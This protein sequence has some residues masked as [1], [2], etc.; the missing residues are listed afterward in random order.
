MTLTEL[1]YIV[2]V[3]AEGQGEGPRLRGST[4]VRD[5]QRPPVLVEVKGAIA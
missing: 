4:P 2:A 5:R 3:F 1:K